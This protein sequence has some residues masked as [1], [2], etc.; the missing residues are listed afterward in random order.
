MAPSLP[1]Q[2]LMASCSVPKGILLLPVKF[3]KTKKCQRADSQMTNSRIYG[4]QIGSDESVS[5]DLLR[6]VKEVHYDLHIY[7][8]HLVLVHAWFLC[9]IPLTNQV[10]GSYC[11]LQTKLFPLG[12]K[13]QE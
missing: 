5:R 7:T 2:F 3:L 10:Q 6:Q 8:V 1:V 11:N 9:C 4:K 12:Y 13:A